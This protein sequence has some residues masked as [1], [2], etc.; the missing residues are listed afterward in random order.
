MISQVSNINDDNNN[1]NDD[2]NNKGQS[3]YKSQNNKSFSKGDDLS[4]E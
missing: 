4:S 2:D 3:M 1:N